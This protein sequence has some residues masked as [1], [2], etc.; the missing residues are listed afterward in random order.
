MCPRHVSGGGGVWGCA[1]R[2]ACRGIMGM[3]EA[4]RICW[5]G[6]GL[7]AGTCS[8]SDQSGVCIYVPALSCS[9]EEWGAERQGRSLPEIARNG[10]R[11]RFERS[12]DLC[13][14]TCVLLDCWGIEI[15]VFVLITQTGCQSAL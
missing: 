3:L 5:G 13:L 15:N 2:L 12:Y 11:D 14:R 7:I 9:E 6:M 4:H 1:R 10:P 8:Q